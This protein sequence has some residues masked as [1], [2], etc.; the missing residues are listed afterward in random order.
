MLLLTALCALQGVP[1]P[2]GSPPSPLG[3]VHD[4]LYVTKHAD[5]TWIR[6]RSYKARVAPGGFR[7]IPFLGSSAPRNH[8]LDMR[9]RSARIGGNELLLTDEASV[10]REGDRFVLDRGPVDVLY[11][12]ALESV[13]QSFLLDVAGASDDLVLEIDVSTDLTGA[14]AANGH[15]FRCPRGGVDYSAAIVLDGAGR[16]ASIPSVLEGDTMRLTV[17]AHFLAAAEGPVLVDPVFQT[18]TVDDFSEDLSRP[19]VVFDQLEIENTY[20]YMEKFSGADFDVFTRTMDAI[21]NGL[22]SGNYFD[23]SDAQVLD[24]KIATCSAAQSNLVVATRLFPDGS[25]EILGR[26]LLGVT[27]TFGSE[28]MIASGDPTEQL[29]G[30]DVG[31]NTDPSTGTPRYLVAWTRTVIG[32]SEIVQFRTVSSNSALGVVSNTFG[33]QGSSNLSVAVSKDTSHYVGA[34][35][36]SM[37]WVSRPDPA[38]PWRIALMQ[39]DPD[40]SVALGIGLSP[41]LGSIPYDLD[42]SNMLLDSAGQPNYLVSYDQGSL[43]TPSAKRLL[44]CRG[45]DVVQEHSLSALEHGLD[46]RPV[47]GMRLGTAWTPNI[48]PAFIVAY[49]ELE[50]QV[51][52]SARYTTLHMN[53]PGTLAVAERRRILGTTP[54]GTGSAPAIATRAASPSIDY[55]DFGVVAWTT[56]SAVNATTDIAG[57]VLDFNLQLSSG[58]QYCYG[59]PNSTDQR[60]FLQLQGDRSTNTS[61]VLT[62]VG[63]PP[64]VFGF[65]IMGRGSDELPGA[66]GSA[67]TLCIGG[68][69]IGRDTQFVLQANPGGGIL[70]V[71]D[72]A[73]LITSTGTQAAMS[74]ERWNFQFWHR[75]VAGGTATSNFTNAVALTFE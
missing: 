62:G 40:G 59:S 37:A 50:P 21:S 18:F 66:G 7:Y 63:L 11:D 26:L 43:F 35:R 52:W 55:G 49:E 42:V 68:A 71:L 12:V 47:T 61:K 20:V 74:G 22:V 46:D 48:E 19:D 60:G 8:P 25:T 6:G 31:G 1:A 2:A 32:G 16:S 24:P 38:S 10:T 41:A 5:G 14:A 56:V 69:E 70:R 36:W 13:E 3:G 28:L 4:H 29:S 45:K 67:G 27:N 72:P 53:V 54:G 57:A 34:D 58:N 64:G 39:L 9:L 51:G 33:P 65:F 73:H 17:P 30:P 75:D 23:S 15:Q 44:Q